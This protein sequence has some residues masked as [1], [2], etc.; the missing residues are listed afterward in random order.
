MWRKY[1][2]PHGFKTQILKL[3]ESGKSMEE[4]VKEYGIAKWK[5]NKRSA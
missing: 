2:Y 3:R 5:I 1:N 4:I